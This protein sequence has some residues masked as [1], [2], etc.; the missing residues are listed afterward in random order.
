MSIA[1]LVLACLA[2]AAH[3]RR[4]LLTDQQVRWQGLPRKA[5]DLVPMVHSLVKLDR[6]R[7]RQ[8]FGGA[9]PFAR[10]T[11]LLLTL[12]PATA[13]RVPGFGHKLVANT[14]RVECAEF[15]SRRARSP[16]LVAMLG[17]DVVGTDCLRARLHPASRGALCVQMKF[18]DAT[19]EQ[20]P[21]DAAL[22]AGGE[23]VK[24]NSTMKMNSTEV[25]DPPDAKPERKRVFAA[26][27]WRALRAACMTRKA[28]Q[29][30]TIGCCADLVAQVIDNV[31]SIYDF[32]LRQT[33]A[34]TLWA[35]GYGGGFRVVISDPLFDYVFGLGT[36]L[37]VNTMKTLTEIFVYTPAFYI[38][39][40]Y[41]T[42]GLI[43]G[44]G[45][46]G[47]FHK[48]CDRFV[49]TFLAHI[50]IWLAPMY[51]YFAYIP[52]SNRVLFRAFFAFIQKCVYSYLGMQA[53]LPA[54]PV[55]LLTDLPAAG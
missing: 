43:Q 44:L 42:T 47:A 22:S 50:I 8:H 26:R 14:R 18:D 45:W 5:G 21:S 55:E 29:A 51:V 19:D 20:M 16:S 12:Q 2:C 27:V 10:L 4:L 40:F 46:M 53:Q 48:L 41:M 11:S 9:D 6:S 49:Q 28:L 33:L 30:G 23:D 32:D 31:R 3:G 24:I 35:W 36:G 38:P 1:T 15:L 54:P 25:I 52:Y 39:T 13:W 34:M 37:K 7:C 17:R